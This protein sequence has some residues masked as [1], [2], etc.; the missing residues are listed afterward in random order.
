M[1]AAQITR[2]TGTARI[3]AFAAL[4]K[5]IDVLDTRSSDLLAESAD[6]SRKI[7]GNYL[8]SRAESSVVVSSVGSTHIDVAWKWPLRQTRQKAVRSALTALNLMDHYPA[9]S[10]LLTQPQVYEFIR[11]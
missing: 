1:L 7:L 10:F 2:K 5:A 11:E 4:E 9:F 6:S 3:K 8:E